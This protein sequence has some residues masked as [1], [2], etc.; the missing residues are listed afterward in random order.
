MQSD[1]LEQWLLSLPL[2]EPCEVEGERVYLNLADGGAEI[3]LVLLVQASAAQVADALR[4]AFQGALE[5]E[6]GLA[7]APDGGDLL[8]N[9][10]LPGVEAWSDVAEALDELLSQAALVRAAM[11]SGAGPSDAVRRDD[12]RMRRA[13]SG[14]LG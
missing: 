4:T 11:A 13:L 2:Q 6:A 5:Y 9:R 7:L 12:E 10:W 1:E 3:G 14:E 8:L